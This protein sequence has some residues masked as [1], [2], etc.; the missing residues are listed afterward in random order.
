MRRLIAPLFAFL[1]TALSLASVANAQQGGPTAEPTLAPGE[2][3]GVVTG[4]LRNGTAGGRIRGNLAV[5]LHA[6]D[7]THETVM[8]NGT[9]DA[10]G[11]FRF[12]NVSMK[13][14]WTFA[15]M[16]SYNNVTF[17]SDP[18][19][20]QS[21]LKELAVP[22]T[23]YETTTDTAKVSVSQLHAFLEFAAGEVQVNE[24]YVLSNLSDRAI[25][26]AI[27]L[28]DGS[29]AGLEFAL[30][31]GASAVSFKDNDS[32]DRFVVTANGFADT[33]PLVPGQSIQQVLVSY[34]LPYQTGMTIAHG[35]PYAVEG[36]SVLHRRNAGVTVS[37]PTLGAATESDLGQGQTYTIHPGSAQ[38]AGSIL[39]LTVSGQANELSPSERGVAGETQAPSQNGWVGLAERYAL[40]ASASLFGLA[41]IGTG[42]WW[43][44]RNRRSEFDARADSDAELASE[45]ASGD[46]DSLLRRIAEL[47]D[48]HERGEVAEAEYVARRAALKAQARAILQT[49]Q[50]QP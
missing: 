31:A 33:A 36:L 23:V 18:V 49:E 27:T 46:W 47:D 30:P 14:G 1:L 41:L 15:A 12:E 45:S 32:A 29:P 7:D 13:D 50:A 8:L 19:P 11:A 42:A 5:T 22:L 43:L 10:Q 17:F 28:P 16:T 25:T 38:G 44:R 2:R 37:G 6:W 20:L 26:G 34:S 35:L 9:M 39:Q 21:G 24:V 48:A 4:Q 40:P 3:K